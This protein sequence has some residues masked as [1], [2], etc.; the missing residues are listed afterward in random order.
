MITFFLLQDKTIVK[1]LALSVELFLV[2]WIYLKKNN[3]F[4]PSILGRFL[5]VMIVNLQNY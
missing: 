5:R 2:L 3:F 1:I 4:R